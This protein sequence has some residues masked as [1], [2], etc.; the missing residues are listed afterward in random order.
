MLIK[1][2]Y[3]KEF[4]H[5]ISALQKALTKNLEILCFKKKENHQAILSLLFSEGL[6]SS[7]QIHPNFL[8]IRLKPFSKTLFTIKTAQRI[9]RKNLTVSTKELISLQ[10]QAGASSYFILSTDYG[11][12]TSLLAIEKGIGGKL[13]LKIS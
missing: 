4:F 10:R 7:F 13:I 12:L 3:S 6:I 2:K 1:Q 8:I 9:G 5:L 11:F